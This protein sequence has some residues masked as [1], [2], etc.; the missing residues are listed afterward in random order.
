[1]AGNFGLVRFAVVAALGLTASDARAQS[2]DWVAA[3]GTS[4][5]NLAPA[6]ISNATVRLIARVTIPGEAVRFR[7]DNTYGTAPVT[8]GRATVAPRVRG[9]AVAYGL[10]RPITFH[11][12]G[13]VTIPA[14][15]IDESDPVTMHVDAQEDLAVSL[16][17][18]GNAQPSQHAN[19]VVTSYVT[20]NDAGD[21]TDNVDGKP[22]GG[23]VTAM[24]W[25]KG[26]DVRPTARATAIVAFGDSITD[27]TCTTLDA[28]DRWEDIVAQRLALQNPVRFAIVNEGIGGNTVTNA[29]GYQPA[30]NSAPAWNASSATS[31]RMSEF[32]TWSFLWAPTTS[33]AAPPRNS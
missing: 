1:M 26:I 18:S 15:T 10:V 12:K 24:Y 30:I 23:H 21:T 4:Q 11:G 25:L 20:D 17:V 3:W 14:G 8:F 28:H 7:L 31:C 2:G 9:A 29:A 22:F 27:G 19:A 5:Q 33:G 16:F 6:K 13:T 32:R